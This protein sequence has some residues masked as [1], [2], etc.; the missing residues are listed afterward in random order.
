MFRETQLHAHQTE[1]ALGEGRGLLR[2]LFCEHALALTGERAAAASAGEVGARMSMSEW[3]GMWAH[4]ELY[5]AKFSPA[6]AKLCAAHAQ[7]VVTD[8]LRRSDAFTSL[9]FADFVEAVCRVAMVKP[10]PQAEQMS[11]MG[12]RTHY[13]FV[14]A[15]VKLGRYKAWLDRAARAL[16]PY[17]ERCSRE[18]GVEVPI[19]EEVRRLLTVLAQAREREH[20]RAVLLALGPDAAMPRRRSI[21]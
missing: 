11:R 21:M 17:A 7:S 19:A 18:S 4:F 3:V 15:Q 5:D 1:Q 16:P 20:D 9:S 14:D 2:G 10:I 8:A 12:M 6:H 13:D